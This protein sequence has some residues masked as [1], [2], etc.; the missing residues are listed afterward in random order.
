MLPGSTVLETVRLPCSSWLRWEVLADQFIVFIQFKHS[1]GGC[2]TEEAGQSFFNSHT[3][4]TVVQLYLAIL[5]KQFLWPS[6]AAPVWV[7]KTKQQLA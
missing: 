5:I 2:F 6:I 7:F 4:V 3:A 1:A